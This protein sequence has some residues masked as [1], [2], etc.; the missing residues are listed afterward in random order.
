ML[1]LELIRSRN[2]IEEVVQE[3]FG[4]KKSG[5]HFVGIDHDSLVVNPRT[6]WYHWNSQ[7]DRGDVFD[8]V[9]RHVLGNKRHDAGAFLEAV[10]Y[11]SERA[12][13][14]MASSAEIKQ[15]P[16]WNERELIRR[17]EEALH[18]DET[19]F[20]YATEVRGWS[21]E[22]LRR[23]RL[24]Y[25]PRD[26][27][28][29]LS[30]LTLVGKWFKTIQVFPPGMLVYVH[31]ENGRLAYLSGRSITE[32]RHYNPPRELADERCPY[33]NHLYHSSIDEVVLVEGQADA[34]SFASWGMAAVA[35][36]GIHLNDDLKDL[37]KRHRRVFVLLD[38]TE[39]ARAKSAEMARILGPTTCLPRLPED[40]KDANDWLVIKQPS[41]SLVTT[42]LNRA[43]T[44]VDH[45]VSRIA[46][47]TGLLR[48]DGVEQLIEQ[49]VAADW[50]KTHLNQLRSLMK[51]RLKVSSGLF[52]D[53]LKASQ[54]R[55]QTDQS[56]DDSQI[57]GED[58]PLISPALGFT[59][60][61]AVITVSIMERTTHNRLNLQPYLVTSKRELR[62][63][64][65]QQVIPLNGHEAALR[66]VPEGSE[67]LRRWRYPDIQRFLQGEVVSPG[68]V[69]HQV[70]QHFT[71]YVEFCSSV[72]SHIVALWVI[73]TYFYTLFGAYPYLAL[74]GPKNSGKSTLLNAAKPLA[75]NM[76]TTSDIT[77]PSLFRLIH[78]NACTVGIDEAE[79]YHSPRDPEMQ[80]IKLLL[81]S[82]YKPGMP[83]IR[84]MGEDLK[85]QAFDVYSPKILAN[86]AGLEDVLA[87]RCI[88]IAMRRSDQKLPTLSPTINGQEIR[89]QLY[90]LALTRYAVIRRNY[91]ERPEL[92]KLINRSHELWSPLVA[93][94]AFFEEEGPIEGLL[95]S[96]R[97]AATRDD[98]ISEGKSL[99]EREEALLQALELLSKDQK[100]VT[101]KARDIRD[102]VQ[103]LLELPDN[104]LGNNQWVGH[105]L[106]HLQL[107]DRARSHR[108]ND[109]MRYDIDRDQVLDMMKRYGVAAIEMSEMNT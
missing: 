73:G 69:F 50:D 106:K 65:D 45:E 78:Y 27:K 49:A 4:L 25:M 72:D 105:S 36:G 17:L 95:Q 58:I 55:F 61:M 43:E 16:A 35:L 14:P 47:L 8:F 12:G 93:L 30:G 71:R 102:K 104:Q 6:G 97:E 80:Q 15:S 41:A 90:I 74:N 82:G 88:P 70:H 53:L 89:H 37:L 60:E 21:S 9:I 22:V 48:Q 42:L 39:E 59:P 31:R 83:A 46:Q 24:G 63:L 33:F 75:F 68:E 26:K 3:K 62:R 108:Q 32:K 10:R 57:L 28:A 20:Q 98:L 19:A 44:L 77:G 96:I 13:L 109:G 76:I 99:N 64:D 92:H 38:N 23:E 56:G 81:N 107:T 5:A 67:F 91:D 94:A 29:L 11:L 34:I 2:P 86:I 66:V 7:A 100:L 79:R 87:S 103:K 1:D 18:Q 84:L 52:N 51:D 101:L 40:I 54:E 85:P